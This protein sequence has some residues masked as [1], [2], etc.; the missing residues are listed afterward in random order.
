[1]AAQQ[2][3]QTKSFSLE[4]QNGVD[5]DGAPTFR[6]RTFSKVKLDATPDAVLAVAEGIKPLLKDPTRDL[7]VND[8]S[9]VES[10]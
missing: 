5:K 10:V 1:M 2:T 4:V 3:L 9:S 7:Y 6:K 8:V